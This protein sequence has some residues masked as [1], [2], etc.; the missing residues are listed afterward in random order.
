MET[1][2][3]DKPA[4]MCCWDIYEIS[5]V[6]PFY[7]LAAFYGT[8]VLR[9]YYISAIVWWFSIRASCL[10]MEHVRN[11]LLI[12]PLLVELVKGFCVA[13]FAT[14]GLVDGSLIGTAVFLLALAVLGRW[15]CTPGTKLPVRTYVQVPI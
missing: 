14:Y 12:L 6:L 13:M 4:S 8:R 9:T 11:R 1:I 3:R 2:P 7:S 5:V 10:Y 15:Q